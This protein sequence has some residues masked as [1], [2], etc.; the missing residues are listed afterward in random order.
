MRREDSADSAAGA[1]GCR[2]L[3]S[4]IF[5]RSPSN[6]SSAADRD[7]EEEESDDLVPDTV[8][9]AGGDEDVDDEA[10]ERSQ[11]MLSRYEVLLIH[12]ALEAR[13][14][15]AGDLAIPL[16]RCF[17]LSRHEHLT[18]DRMAE[19][20]GSGHSRV[21]VFDGERRNVCG[22][23]LVKQLIVINPDDGRQVGTLGL[24]MPI[25]VDE[26][27]KLLLNKFQVGHSHMAMVVSQD[28]ARAQAAMRDPEAAMPEDVEVLGFC[29]FEDVI[30]KLLKEP[31]LDETD[32]SGG[33]RGAFRREFGK[34]RA[35]NMV[36]MMKRGMLRRQSSRLVVVHVPPPAAPKQGASAGQV[37][38]QVALTI[39]TP[40]AS[41]L[42]VRSRSQRGSYGTL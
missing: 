14:I 3:F 19:I 41:G 34:A 32:K 36:S 20:L 18:M 12:G 5:T 15:C 29:T 11:T 16:R 17:M 25:V 9:L 37:V 33:V 2:N 42:G 23:L 28:A 7:E 39:V 31:I 26:R 35:K 10:E 40:P 24:R 1:G 21:P 22:I 6:G 8:G 30:E 13:R 4:G 27:V 38:P